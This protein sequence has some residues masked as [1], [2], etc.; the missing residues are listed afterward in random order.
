MKIKL[1]CNMLIEGK[2]VQAG[3]IIEIK[4]SS[5]GKYISK[6][7]GEEIKKEVKI[8]KETKE[9]KISKETKNETNKD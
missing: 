7:W 4:E 6:G 3:E 9:L 1:L 8:K 5:L 2:Q